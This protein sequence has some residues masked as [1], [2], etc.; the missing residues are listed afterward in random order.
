MH[1]TGLLLVGTVLD[2]LGDVCKKKILSFHKYNQNLEICNYTNAICITRCEKI[3][4]VTIKVTPGDNRKVRIHH[5]TGLTTNT[6]DTQSDN[7]KSR[8]I[9]AVIGIRVLKRCSTY[10]RQPRN[11]QTRINTRSNTLSYVMIPANL[12]TPQL[13]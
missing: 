3:L 1:S 6:L 2:I 13:F 8:H 7:G 11:G 10:Y 5:A 9:I 4:R 12:L